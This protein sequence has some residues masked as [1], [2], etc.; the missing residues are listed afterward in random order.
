MN[1]LKQLFCR[2]DWHISGEYHKWFCGKK[3]YNKILAVS[4]ECSK[5]GKEMAVNTKP[6][7]RTEAL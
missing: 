4:I 1:R 6:P 7:K 3:E 2:H 5:C